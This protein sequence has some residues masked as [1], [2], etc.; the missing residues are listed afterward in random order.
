MTSMVVYS[1][2]AMEASLDAS[3]ETMEEM[4]SDGMFGWGT[5]FARLKGAPYY[6]VDASVL[7]E[8]T[9]EECQDLLTQAKIPVV[10]ARRLSQVLKVQYKPPL[11][12]AP[13]S[14]Q[15]AL[16]SSSLGITPSDSRD[17]KRFPEAKFGAKQRRQEVRCSS[18]THTP[19]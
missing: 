9:E 7:S 19:T 17:S 15:Q 10:M 18:A 1:A 8:I 6:G 11:G 4:F 16:V 3:Q 12:R 5:F 14:A 13:P 2:S